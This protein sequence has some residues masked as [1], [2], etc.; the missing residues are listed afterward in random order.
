MYEVIS[1][2]FYV[3]IKSINELRN[4]SERLIIACDIVP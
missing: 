2:W 4:V 3:D 1:A